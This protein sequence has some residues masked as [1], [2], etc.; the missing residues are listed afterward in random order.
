MCWVPS[1]AHIFS[2]SHDLGRAGGKSKQ[3]S[4][5]V[6]RSAWNPGLQSSGSSAGLHSSVYLTAPLPAQQRQEAESRHL[7][8]DWEQFSQDFLGSREKWSGNDNKES[9][10]ESWPTSRPRVHRVWGSRQPL[11]EKVGG[12]DGGSGVATVMSS[13]H[14][15]VSITASW[16]RKC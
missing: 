9:K 10:G 16:Q 14:R 6:L 1:P 5:Q 8:E 15:Q 11:L 13:A 3:A 2:R 7:W 12:G 4:P